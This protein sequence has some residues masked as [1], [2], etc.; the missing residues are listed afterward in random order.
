MR[1]ETGHCFEFDNKAKI[2]SNALFVKAI[3]I[4]FHY[5]IC[6]FYISLFS[7]SH[8]ATGKVV[9]AEDGNAIIG[10]SVLE[11]GT[12]NGTATDFDGGI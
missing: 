3:H 4:S 11:K 10:A 1:R 5:N 7:Q 12:Q 2:Q 9:S 8:T 6:G